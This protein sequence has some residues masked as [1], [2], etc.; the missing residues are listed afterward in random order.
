LVRGG[1]LA[2]NKGQARIV[3]GKG[4]RLKSAAGR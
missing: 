1:G 4:V 3:I 2:K